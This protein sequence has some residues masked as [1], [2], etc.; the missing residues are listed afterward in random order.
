MHEIVSIIDTSNGR[1]YSIIPTSEMIRLGI[2]RV[3]F[4]F[5][6]FIKLYFHP[7]GILE[8]DA[9]KHTEITNSKGKRILYTVQYELSE[10]LNDRNKPC[11]EDPQYRKDNCIEGELEKLV[12]KE[13]GCT[14]PFFENKE[15]ICTNET[16]SKQVLEVWSSKKYFT[17]CSDP[18]KEML[19]STT[20]L[21][22]KDQKVNYHLQAGIY[23]Q[24]RVKVMKS[25]YAYSG[26][27]L[28]AEIGGYFGLFLGVSINQIT[29][30]TSFI[31]ERVQKYL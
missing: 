10:M 9:V 24:H 21:K 12:M 22:N 3:E 17:N 1:C 25:F 28:I 6:S 8:Y 11:H 29:Y 23:F 16:I 15:N 13:F 20:W 14:P 30:L 26:L 7:P 31:H 19:V 27:S 18:C 5:V 4:G 2:R